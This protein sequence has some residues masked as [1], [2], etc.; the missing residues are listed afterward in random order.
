MVGDKHGAKLYPRK[1]SQMSEVDVS[2]LPDAT[3]YKMDM[4]YVHE[5]S[6]A[7]QDEVVTLQI[8]E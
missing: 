4:Y 3:R 2:D 8:R 6:E 5:K 1:W 7:L